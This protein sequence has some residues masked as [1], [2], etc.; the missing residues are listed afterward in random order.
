MRGTENFRNLAVAALSASGIG[1]RPL[2]DAL[3]VPGASFK[4]TK[5]AGGAKSPK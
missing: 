4:P 5:Q 1:P 3:G 2:T